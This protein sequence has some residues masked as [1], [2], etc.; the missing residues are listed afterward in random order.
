MKVNILAIHRDEWQMKKLFSDP[1]PSLCSAFLRGFQRQSAVRTDK[2]LM[3]V[4]EPS[5]ATFFYNFALTQHMALVFWSLSFRKWGERVRK[6]F[7]FHC[8]SIK[9][10]K[11]VKETRA[12]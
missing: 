7:F 8:V 9:I 10:W 4:L 1:R 2:E 3:R 5:P 11:R 12:E 6:T